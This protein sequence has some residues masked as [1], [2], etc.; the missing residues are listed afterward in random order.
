M[1]QQYDYC[2]TKI[3][4]RILEWYHQYLI[5]PGTTRMEARIKQTLTWPN[6]R[7]DDEKYV[8]TCKQC[9]LCKKQRN[10]YGKLPPK[11][12]EVPEP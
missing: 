4:K 5:Y 10:K 8:K 3:K 9:Q 6:L 11:E 1:L 7:K 2:T 12:A